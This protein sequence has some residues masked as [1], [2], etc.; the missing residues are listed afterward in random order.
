MERD[1]MIGQGCSNLIVDRLFAASD[2]YSVYVCDI[3][4]QIVNSPEYCE[5]CEN[6]EIKL[7][8]IP[9]AFKLLQKQLLALCIKLAIFPEDM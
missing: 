1:C 6:T 4:G 3:C 2:P 8:K 9:Y 7:I 5:A